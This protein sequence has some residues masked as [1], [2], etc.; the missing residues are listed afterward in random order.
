MRCCI[1]RHWHAC[2]LLP[3]TGKELVEWGS[4]VPMILNVRPAGKHTTAHAWAA[5]GVPRLL[6]ELRE[7][8]DLSTPTLDGTPLGTMLNQLHI[9]GW[10]AHQGGKL[11]VFGLAVDEVTHP[12]SDPF[13]EAPNLVWMTGNL[14]PEGAVAK[15]N[16]AAPEA[17][18]IVGRARCYRRSDPCLQDILSGNV[19]PGSVLI[20]AGEGP[21]AAGMP[22]QYYVTEALAAHPELSKQVALVTDGRFSGGSRGP[23]VGHVTPEAAAGG[24][25]GL[26]QDGDLIEVDTTRAR[27]NLVGSANG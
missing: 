14:A 10:F 16:A 15:P 18:R 9:E 11:A 20:I 7:L 13:A 24:P 3:I 17:R 2:L 8:L 12:L 21:Q 19:E 6:W 27:L 23:M 5:G 1:W 22:E 4:R 26:V 25:I